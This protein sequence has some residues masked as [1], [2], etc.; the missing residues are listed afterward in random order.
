ME[1]IRRDPERGGIF[2]RLGRILGSDITGAADD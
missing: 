2:T 1:N